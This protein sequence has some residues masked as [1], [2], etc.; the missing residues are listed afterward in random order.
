MVG[1]Y[2]VQIS[3]VQYDKL[4]N[5]KIVFPWNAES[6]HRDRGIQGPGMV[7]ADYF[8]YHPFFFEIHEMLKWKVSWS[9]VAQNWWL[10]FGICEFDQ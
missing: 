9:P 8:T 2:H 1:R 3:F 6:Q 5:R 10:R 4:L 7:S